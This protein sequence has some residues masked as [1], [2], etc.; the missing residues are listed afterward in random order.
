MTTPPSGQWPDPNYPPPPQTGQ[1]TYSGGYQV[2]PTYQPGAPGY[3]QQPVYV[4][5]QPRTNGLALAAMIVALCGFA[6]PL[7]FPAGAIMGHISQKQVR[8][9][10]EQGAGYAKT[11]IIVG[12]I[13]T[14]LFIIGCGAYITFFVFLF[15]HVN[16]LPANN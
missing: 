8:E 4:V 15:N 13:G 2:P 7:A 9:T 14:G 12:W 11:G 3:G 5:A 6:F 16:N 1:P 10:G